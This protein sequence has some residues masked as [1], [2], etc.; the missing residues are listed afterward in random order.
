MRNN[1]RLTLINLSEN[2]INGREFNKIALML[3]VNRDLS[4][5][6]LAS[7]GL[8]KDAITAIGEGLKKNSSLEHLDLS[9]NSRLNGDSF[10]S[11]AHQDCHGV[12]FLKSLN[13]TDNQAI[14]D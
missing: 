13:L 4:S 9:K 14:G 11:W 6:I 10:T 1:S 7:C 8:G 5:L 12:F 3:T 2:E